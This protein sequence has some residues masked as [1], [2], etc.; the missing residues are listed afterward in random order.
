MSAFVQLH[1]DDDVVVA[2]TT[3]PAGTAHEGVTARGRIEMG[4]KMAIRSLPVGSPL[5]KY[6]QKIGVLTQP[7]E[8]G[9]WVHTHNLGL[10]E[11]SHSYQFST[12]VPPEPTPITGRTF[13]GYRRPDGRVG[14]RNYI[15]IVSTVNCSATTSKYIAKQFDPA[16][17][18]DFPNVDG[19]IPLV[20]KGGCAMAF[21]CS[22][23][24]SA[25]LA[26][27]D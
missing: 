13:M 14:T 6:G 2:R 11:L 9:D 26:G 12:E 3:V 15:A 7:V 21:F 17:L 4:H 16:V 5:R 10:G 23:L 18:A 20:H 25:G 19:I 1:P 22:T 27:S 24:P 8:A